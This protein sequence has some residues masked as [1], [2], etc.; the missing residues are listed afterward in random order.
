[1]NGGLS[2]C[3][4]NQDSYTVLKNYVTIIPIRLGYGGLPV[5]E[6]AL[7]VSLDEPVYH[8][9]FYTLIQQC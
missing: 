4:F 1:M 7:C 6:N 5:A 3:Q 9:Y 2:L 8:L